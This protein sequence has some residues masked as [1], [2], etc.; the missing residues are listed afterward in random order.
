METKLIKRGNKKIGADTLIFNMAPA[1]L[2]PSRD[3]SLCQI[4]HKCYALKAE[5]QYHHVVPQYRFR[6]ALF[7]LINDAKT[8]AN[9]IKTKANNIRVGEIKYVRLN[10]SGD[11][12]DQNCVKK[13]FEV[14]NEVPK[15]RFYIYTARRDLNFE[16][17]PEN[18]T[19]NGSGFM[20]DN[21]FNPVDFPTGVNTCPNDCRTCDMCK[22]SDN[23][24][25]EVVIH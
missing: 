24:E 15:L 18:L 5:K 6:Q 12:W 23:K 13:L 14:C 3:K 10:E 16:G 21:S 22:K 9:T 8:I 17:R 25:I 11:F 19:I 1:E 2:C 20:V 4:A 7:W